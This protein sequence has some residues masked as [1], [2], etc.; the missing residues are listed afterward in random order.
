MIPCYIQGD[1]NLDQLVKVAFARFPHWE[2]AIF[3]FF[4]SLFIITESL[5]LTEWGLQAYLLEKGVSIYIHYLKFFCK[6]V[7]LLSYLLI[8]LF[9]YVNIDL[10]ISIL[11]LSYNPLLLLIFL[12]RFFSVLATRISF[13][14]P[15]VLFNTVPF[16]SFF[17]SFAVLPSFIFSSFPFKLPY[18][19]VMPDEYCIVILYF[20]CP[21]PKIHHFLRWLGSFYW[22]MV[23]INQ[24]L[25][26]GYSSCYWNDIASRS[27]WWRI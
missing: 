24:D 16:L 27:S 19:L 2:V 18:F 15:C 4:F 17:F 11:Y 25:V 23:F 7:S 6:D 14:L 1:I 13:R 21:N 9:I 12:L 5:N 8:Q 10:Y 3:T 22:K 20:F 26:A